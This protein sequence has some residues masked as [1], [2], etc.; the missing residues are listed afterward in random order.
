MQ[1]FPDK[2]HSLK[3]TQRIPSVVTDTAEYPEGMHKA[4]KSFSEGW[5]LR[6]LPVRMVINV[7]FKMSLNLF[8]HGICLKL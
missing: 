7:D 6:R 8:V 4:V 2:N 1:D 5:G 3:A